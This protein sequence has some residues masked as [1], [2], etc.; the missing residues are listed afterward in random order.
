MTKQIYDFK[1]CYCDAA[2]FAQGAKPLK[3]WQKDELLLLY[4][5]VIAKN[6]TSGV[7]ELW[8]VNDFNLDLSP[9]AQKY[10]MKIKS[11]VKMENI[12]TLASSMLVNDGVVIEVD[13]LEELGEREASEIVSFSARLNIPLLVHFGQDLYSLGALDKKYRMPPERVLE[14]LGFLDRK[15]YLFGCN[16]LDKDALSLFENYEVE[17]IFSP[18]DD[19]EKGRGFLNFKL[20]EN[21][22]CHLAS[23][24]GEIDMTG[25]ANFLR[26][27]TNNLLSS[28]E[29]I[30]LSSYGRLLPFESDDDKIL[31]LLKSKITLPCEN[32]AEL[33]Q[34][35]CNLL[36]EK[37]EKN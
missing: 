32:F 33:E 6:F 26:L 22:V 29:M 16:Y 11:I 17:H 8:I 9:L 20:Y 23:R 5:Y 14:E 1:N 3:S 2:C 4:E 28:A 18:L 27:S 36:A 7:K 19:G 30:A 34:K 25:N 12:N 13:K 37:R 15:C 31:R 35:F 21:K 10:S 24:E